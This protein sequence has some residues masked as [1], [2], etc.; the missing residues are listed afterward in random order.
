[1]VEKAL[2]QTALFADRDKL[3]TVIRG[4]I[5]NALAFTP[6]KCSVKVKVMRVRS[7]PSRTTITTQAHTQRTVP[8][9]LQAYIRRLWIYRKMTRYLRRGRHDSFAYVEDARRTQERLRIEIVD[10]GP[11]ISKVGGVIAAVVY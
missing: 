11:G 6:K 4:L 1:M 7:V 3:G 10:E 9:A 5:F 8:S 2:Q